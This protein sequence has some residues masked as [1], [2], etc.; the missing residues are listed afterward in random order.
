MAHFIRSAVLRG[1]RWN[2]KTRNFA[3][4]G[5]CPSWFSFLVFLDRARSTPNMVLPS[6]VDL[7]PVFS[8]QK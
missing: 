7:A 6:R 4:L 1:T 5:D 2:D 3:L 8:L